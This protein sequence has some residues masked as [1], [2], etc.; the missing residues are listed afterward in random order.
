MHPEP[1]ADAMVRAFELSGSSARAL[2][3]AIARDGA[4]LK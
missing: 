1:I 4:T 3:P 2:T